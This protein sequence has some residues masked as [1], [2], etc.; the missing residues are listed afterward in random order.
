ML[1]RIPAAKKPDRMFEIVFPACQIAILIG[2]SSLVYH[3][4]V[5]KVIP[6]KKGAS[7]RPM[8]NRQ[9]AKPAPLVMAGIQIVPKLH[10]NII[11]G[12][13]HLGSAFAS[14]RLPGS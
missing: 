14:H 3:E 11:M 2:F 1:V 7:V 13:N 4:E 6:G 10:P 8:K 5:I 9:T 12:R